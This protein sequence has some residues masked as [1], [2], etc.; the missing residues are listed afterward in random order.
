MFS[1]VWSDTVCH[2]FLLYFVLELYPEQSNISSHLLTPTKIYRFERAN[3]SGSGD[4]TGGRPGKE[5]LTTLKANE[6]DDFFSN[7]G[8]FTTEVILLFL[9]FISFNVLPW[10]NIQR[11][12]IWSRTLL[13]FDVWTFPWNPPFPIHGTSGNDIRYDISGKEY[14]RVKWWCF[15]LYYY[16]IIYWKTRWSLYHSDR[17]NCK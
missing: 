5:Q 17:T 14:R 4:L 11:P 12:I 13:H 1:S 6:I 2:C 9:I 7:S 15:Q 16:V 10:K 3:R 8:D